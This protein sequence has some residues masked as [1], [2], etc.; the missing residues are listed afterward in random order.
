VSGFGGNDTIDG[1]AG[2]DKMTGGERERT[3]LP[4]TT[5][6]RGHRNQRGR[7]LRQGDERRQLHASAPTSRSSTWPPASATA[8]AATGNASNNLLQGNEFNDT[9]DGKA[10]AD[11]MKAVWATTTYIVDNAGDLADETAAA[12]STRSRAR[13][14]PLPWVAVSTT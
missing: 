9:L 2:I 7:R 4:S 5:A 14:R 12:A 13:R 11:T 10:G 6:G 8:L 3:S 1:G